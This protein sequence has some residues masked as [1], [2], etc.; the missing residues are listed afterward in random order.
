MNAVKSG[1]QTGIVVALVVFVVLAFTGIGCGIWFYQQLSLTQQALATNQDDFK[2]AV[3]SVFNE[4]NWEVPSTEESELGVLYTRESYQ[5]VA[6]KVK[7]A[8]VLEN[9]VMPTL[10]W[11]GLAG[12][13][14]SIEN[15][16][17]QQEM[18]SQGKETF[19]T[20]SGLLAFYE[21]RY[22]TLTKLTDDLHAQNMALTNMLKNTKHNLV[23]TEKRLGE[24]YRDKAQRF[25]D[26]I[27]S[28]RKEYEALVTQDE[29]AQ[30]TARTWQQKYQQE[31]DN[32]KKLVADLEDE[33]ALWKQKYWKVVQ[34]PAEEERLQPAGKVISVEPENKF[35]F[36]EGGKDKNIH[37]DELYVVFGRTPGGE[38]RL[39]GT[40][41]IAQVYDK[42]SRAVVREE[43]EYI[44][45]DDFFTPQSLWE[46]FYGEK[47]AEPEVAATA[48]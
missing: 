13:K 32:R 24:E 1:S 3:I 2:S 11:E 25:K 17:A 23:A 27:T 33:L 29:E 41:C 28:L 47:E 12:L 39:K 48:E 42:V 20:L 26:Q 37:P 15:S 9:E 30:Q 10:G 8:A 4:N 40:I 16:P 45:V 46:K 44:L 6:D 14:D 31:V 7:E 36:I 19:K 38:D 5:A 35:V 43:K 34:G 21:E 18:K 22:G